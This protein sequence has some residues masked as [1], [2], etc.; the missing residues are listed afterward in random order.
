LRLAGPVGTAATDGAMRDQPSGRQDRLRRVRLAALPV[1]TAAAGLALAAALTSLT[2]PWAALLVAAIALAA[3][4]GAGLVPGA[5][6]PS[7]AA[8]PPPNPSAWPDSGTQAFA[9]ALAA[10]CFI[11]DRDARILLWSA[12]AARRFG[13]AVPGDPLALRLRIPALGEAAQSV[14]AGGEPGIVRHVER[15]QL[16]RSLAVT[17]TPLATPEGRAVLGVVEDETEREQNERMR[18]DFVAN[19]SHELRTPL[20]ALIG[21]TETLLGPARDDA[22]AR[23]RFLPLMLTE[24]RRMSRL[25]D[26]LLSLSRIERR[27]HLRPETRV[28]LIEVLRHVREAL[29]PL[30]GETGVRV[31]V[32]EGAPLPLRGDRDELIEVFSNL[33]ENGIKY[34]RPGGHVVLSVR[35]E[36]EEGRPGYTVDVADDGPG[37]APED[38]PR[39]TERFYRGAGGTAPRKGTGLG[40]A[41]V[42]HIVARHRGRLSIRSTPGTGSTFSVWLEAAPAGSNRR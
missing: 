35:A 3:F 23:D 2:L 29:A 36:V 32:P 27:A 33:V 22:R 16:D 38:L 20:A 34:N 19:A 31:A 15:A 42:K 26:D 25:V 1:G 10:P 39:V 6:A 21:F 18:A 28:D 5:R 24:A 11:V 41:I 17:L 12:V 14:A 9:D 7:P 8:L 40:L 37:I 4:A 13:P 30:A